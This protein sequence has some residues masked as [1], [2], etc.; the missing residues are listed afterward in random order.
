MHT[1][2]PPS[3]VAHVMSDTY[4]TTILHVESIIITTLFRLFAGFGDLERRGERDE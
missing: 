3:T 4:E 1:C 2:N